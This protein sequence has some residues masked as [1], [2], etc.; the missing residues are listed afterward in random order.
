LRLPKSVSPSIIRP[1]VS[2][3]LYSLL[4]PLLGTS[5]KKNHKTLSLFAK[6]DPVTWAE[7]DLPFENTSAHPFRI[8]PVPCT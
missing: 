1:A 2:C 5:A 7:V 4:L 3:D 6:I 8:P